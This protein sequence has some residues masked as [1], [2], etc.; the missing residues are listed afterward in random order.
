MMQNEF[1]E[2]QSRQVHTVCKAVAMEKH[3]KTIQ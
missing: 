1:S 3:E 2:I